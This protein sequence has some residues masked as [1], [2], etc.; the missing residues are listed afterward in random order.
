MHM[1]YSRIWR[2]AI[3]ILAIFA[4][5]TPA[6][7]AQVQTGSKEPTAAQAAII[8]DEYHRA[9]VVSMDKQETA[10]TGGVDVTTRTYTIRVLDG[11]DKDKNVTM[12]DNDLDSP[13]KDAALKPGDVIAVVK[14][15]AEGAPAYHV[16]DRYRVPA[17]IWFTLLFF[18]AAAVFGGKR[19]MTA[20]LGLAFTV[21]TI[22]WWALP[23]IAHGAPAFRTMI[24][25]SVVIAVVSILLAH[26]A[27][28]R[29][30]LAIG[31]SLGV[32]AFT[33][34]METWF[35]NA[36]HLIG[37]GTEEAFFLSGA[38]MGNIDLRGLLLGGILLGAI[39]VL[40]DITTA[41]VAV[42]AQLKSANP[43]FG[44][45]DLFM[46]GSAVGREH[47]ASLVNTL[48]LAYAG[49]S[50]ALFLLFSTNTTQPLW[51]ILNSEMVSEEII[52]A[53]V[54]SICLVLAVPVSTWIAAQWYA[55]RMPSGELGEGAHG[56][57][58]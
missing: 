58:H 8:P 44:L 55:T 32:L 25:A 28:E 18:A 11:A 46:R 36:S 15:S 42:V 53:L 12:E 48:F 39:G 52:R 23:R 24:I 20:V 43:R 35:V 47:I 38:G 41:Q 22:V 50:L 7:A 21:G 2:I 4:L 34:A 13:V 27:N 17:L 51:F 14:S 33:I 3:A 9:L 26:G 1:Q 49:A 40:D 45:K 30:Y 10:S 57:Q 29:T 31:A 16:A 6:L 5:S 19:G 56:H 37:N 54:G